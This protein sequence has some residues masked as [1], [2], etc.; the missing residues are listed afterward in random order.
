MQTLALDD[1]NNLMIKNGGLFMKKN[2]AALAQD[3]K[4]RVAMC[5]GENPFNILEGI[6]YDDDMLGKLGGAS[7]YTQTIRNRIL[8]HREKIKNI[9]DLVLKRNADTLEVVAH[10]ESEYGVFD[11]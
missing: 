6:N 10:I 5:A 11:L 3:T 4:T 2:I 7:F 9:N 8:E 1:K